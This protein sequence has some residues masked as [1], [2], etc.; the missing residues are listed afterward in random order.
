MELI[1]IRY[2]GTDSDMQR[3]EMSC[4]DIVDECVTVSNGFDGKVD[5]L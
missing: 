3:S 2:R 5:A 1:A 4:E